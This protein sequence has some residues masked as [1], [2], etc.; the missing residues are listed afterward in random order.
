MGALCNIPNNYSKEE[1]NLEKNNPDVMFNAYKSKYDVY[2]EELEDK[3]NLLKFFSITELAILLTNYNFDTRE[4]TVSSRHAVNK[5]LFCEEE[6]GKDEYL[7]FFHKKITE[8]YILYTMVNEIKKQIFIEHMSKIHN[9]CT[10]GKISLVRRNSKQ[11]PNYMLDVGLSKRLKKFFLIA[12]GILYCSG[13][14]LAKMDILF[15]TLS[16]ENSMLER[17]TPTVFFVYYLIIVS[18][19]APLQNIFKLQ[20]YFPDN[21]KEI[22]DEEKLELI[23]AFKVEKLIKLKEKF[24]SDF[25]E[26]A[27]E[28]SY[29]EYQKK[30][31]SEGH[32]WIFSLSGIRSQLVTLG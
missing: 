29:S 1:L 4:N 9:I 27:S 32:D 20:K 19:I 15:Q 11:D 28:I 18:S 21:F 25:F 31:L 8:H 17:N 26:E 3:N 7:T 2:F 24:L 14:N 12:L 10:K 16:N 22:S 6:V 5:R 13:D 30:I 23:E